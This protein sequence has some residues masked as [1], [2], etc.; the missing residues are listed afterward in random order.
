LNHVACYASGVILGDP[1]RTAPKMEVDLEPYRDD[2]VAF[3]NAVNPQPLDAAAPMGG[4]WDVAIK[5][6][7]EKLLVAAFRAI[8]DWLDNREPTA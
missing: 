1:D 7:V 4:L 5:A 2:L 6:L 3:I 8:Q